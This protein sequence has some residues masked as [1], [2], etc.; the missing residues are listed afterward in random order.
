[1][2]PVELQ[3][4]LDENRWDD[5]IIFLEAL[6][7]PLSDE[8]LDKL[9][10][11]YSRAARF[12][13]A[14]N[15]Y[16]ELLRRKPAQA[17][18]HYSVGYQFYGQ[19]DYKTAVEHF[20]KS[21]EI[22]PEYFVVKYRLAYAY[23][24]LAGIY[25]QF[26]KNEFWKAIKHFEDCHSI[27]KNYDDAQAR[28]NKSVYAK[29]CFAHGKA[30]L[31]SLRHIDKTIALLSKAVE[32]KSDEIDYKYN[33]AQ[34]YYNKGNFQTAMETLD[35]L[36]RDERPKYY[37]QEL[38]AQILT[39]VGEPN[40]AILLLLALIRFRKKDYLYQRLAENYLAISNFEK[41]EEYT[42]LAVSSDNKNYKNSLV[43]GEVLRAK[44]Q[45]KT[46]VSYF[47]QAR[48][49][50]QN[51]FSQDCPEAIKAIEEIMLTTDNNPTDT[52]ELDVAPNNIQE[53][54]DGKK[55]GKVVK[56]D[57]F[58]GFGFIAE[59]GTDSSYFMH[60][61]QYP[62]GVIPAVG[63]KVTFEAEKSEKGMRAIKICLK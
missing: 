61:R 30:L 62:Q 57:A 26:S 55:I 38:K 17:S 59:D 19:K 18:Y 40:K 41:A 58:R 56:Y 51:K 42:K 43:Y 13:D 14:K 6:Q 16:G 39:A 47:E 10:W 4:M 33:L 12:D 34:A 32:L 27:Y 11:C 15:V 35:K 28:E 8:M 2:V 36:P 63:Q 29:I 52:L 7:E 31:S 5:G 37:V 44:K 22:Y 25:M 1:M 24:Q 48:I 9:G 53:N 20:E 21:L 60:F 3:K 45:Y 49:K 23:L 50:R 54:G 46:A